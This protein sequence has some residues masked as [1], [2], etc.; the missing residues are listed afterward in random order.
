MSTAVFYQVHAPSD[1]LVLVEHHEI[2]QPGFC[3]ATVSG[4]PEDVADTLISQLEHRLFPPGTKAGSF[5]STTFSSLR[6]TGREGAAMPLIDD[7]IEWVT[8][9]GATAA[10]SPSSLSI[11]RSL[12]TSQQRAL[13]DR[14]WLA[15]YAEAVDVLLGWFL[16]CKRKRA[17][18]S[19]V[20]LGLYEWYEA[21]RSFRRL[22]TAPRFSRPQPHDFWLIALCRAD[23]Q[24]LCLARAYRFA[25]EACERELT[26][27]AAGDVLDS[28]PRCCR[29]VLSEGLWAYAPRR[30]L[31][32]VR[33]GR[34][35]YWHLSCALTEEGGA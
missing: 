20:L 29:P 21:L 13:A 27:E 12:L 26:A 34:G 15:G 3:L 19:E 5:L 11:A 2:R 4:L 17:E 8:S 28:C 14:S 6:R 23:G 35:C 25:S 7:L 33:G 30:T 32:G 9:E 1:S 10:S 18:P 16:T 22:L 31:L 24:A